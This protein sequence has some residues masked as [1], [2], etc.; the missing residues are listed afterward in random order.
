MSENFRK[1]YC[2]CS[3]SIAVLLQPRR[4]RL[5]PSTID[6]LLKPFPPHDEYS[7]TARS[8]LQNSSPLD[9][10]QRSLLRIYLGTP[11]AHLN[12]NLHSSP[13]YASR[14]RHSVYMSI[15]C[16]SP[17]QVSASAMVAQSHPK[18]TPVKDRLRACLI[19]LRQLMPT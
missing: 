19:R 12:A 10:L 9:T 15:R 7:T 13:S 1:T 6:R 14:P 5:D 17:T 2:H 11:A 3:M 8:V 4:G 18:S 16:R